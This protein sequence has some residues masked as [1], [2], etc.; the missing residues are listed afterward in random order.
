MKEEWEQEGDGIRVKR[1]RNDG[2]GKMEKEELVREKGWE[3]HTQ[4]IE[5]VANNKKIR[6]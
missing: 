5:E 6:I 4:E 2:M 3:V 1:E